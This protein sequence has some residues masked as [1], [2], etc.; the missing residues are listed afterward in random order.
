[1]SGNVSEWKSGLNGKTIAIA[2]ALVMVLSFGALGAYGAGE[3]GDNADTAVTTTDP[4]AVV[5]AIQADPAQAYVQVTSQ[6]VQGTG[7]LVPIDTDL[8]FTVVPVEGFT[9][10]DVSVNGQS[11]GAEAG[12]YTVPA[13]E[14]RDTLTISVAATPAEGQMMLAA[15]GQT[16]AVVALDTVEVSY[17]GAVHKAIPNLLDENGNIIEGYY[18]EANSLPEFVNVTNGPQEVSCDSVVIKD[19]DGNDATAL[20]D[21]SF[22]SGSVNIIPAVIKITTPSDTKVYDGTPLVANVVEIDVPDIGEALPLYTGVVATGSQ[23]E[24]GESVNTY[25]IDWGDINSANYTIEE[26]LGT[27]TVTK[28]DAQ[29]VI[30]GPSLDKVYDGTPL[31]ATS[32]VVT[33]P[34]GF[35]VEATVEG[36]QTDAGTSETTVT[37][38]RILDVEGNDITD[39]FEDVQVET[40][41]LT[42]TPAQLAVTTPS[43][44]KAYDGQPLTATAENW[45]VGF[46]N[47]ETATAAITGS[48]TEIG[49]S[50]NTYQITWDGTA[51]EA[52]YTVAEAL[53]TLEV[54]RVDPDATP[55]PT[56]SDNTGAGAAAAGASN[57]G[58]TGGANNAGSTTPGG[59]TAGTTYTPS[60]SSTPIAGTPGVNYL[61]ESNT[62]EAASNTPGNAEG[63]VEAVAEGMQNAARGV[64]GEDPIPLTAPSVTELADDGTPL[65]AFDAPMNNWVRWYVVVGI[66]ATALYG[67]GVLMRRRNFTRGLENQENSLLGVESETAE[68]AIPAADVVSVQ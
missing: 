14:V 63:A 27:L 1:M 2:T 53:G 18:V 68:A 26:N 42:V 21:L 15:A 52:N 11:Y 35:T 40:G 44:Q 59:T 47:N 57:A 16:P 64:I 3:V 46:V 65:G 38:Y 6:T 37:N 60:A 5:V 25:E 20:F 34:E 55:V 30:A 56:P 31:T 61:S 33:A 54:L 62:S 12:D 23:T 43:E 22:Q 50:P 24:V 39:T 51:K 66:I 19:F 28:N 4:T 10:A 48:Q 13:A 8:T 36:S 29:V 32:V 7:L 49:S 45:I 9:I 67:A 17:D 41:K 58:G